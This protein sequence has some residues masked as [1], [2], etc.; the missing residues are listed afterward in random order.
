MRILP[1]SDYNLVYIDCT[2]LVVNVYIDISKKFNDISTLKDKDL[3]KLIFH[4]MVMSL[5]K[6]NKIKQKRPVY[7][8]NRDIM[9][10]FPDKRYIKC[11]IIIFKHLK[12]LLPAP[13]IMLE[14]DIMKKSKGEIKGLN[15]KFTHYYMNSK[16]NTFKLRKYLDSEEFYDLIK[17][18]KDIKNIKSLST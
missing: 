4:Y 9:L 11:F 6:K 15:E 3:K 17:A 5:F 13:L 16:K 10:E 18:L 1:V 14:E 2:D 12:T 7:F 8:F